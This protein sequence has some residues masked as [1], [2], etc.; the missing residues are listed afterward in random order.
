M[1]KNSELGVLCLTEVP[2]DIL[3]WSHYAD[4]HRGLA[5]QFDKARL[6]GAFN[7][8]KEVDYRNNIIE[9]KDIT[10]A[11]PDELAALL[12]LK[13]AIRWKYEKEWRIIVDP[14]LNTIP[15]CRIYR[16]PKEALTG[17]IFGCEMT[18]DDKYTVNAWLKEG[19]HQAQ[20]HQATRDICSYSVRIDPPLD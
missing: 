4:G 10:G 5:F 8:C 16:F 20:V 1:D 3:M 13:K 7:Y 11:T 17:V 6:E 15:G 9:L 2:D 14:N 19:E 12:L 18:A